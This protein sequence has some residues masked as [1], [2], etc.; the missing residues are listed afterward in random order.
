MKLKAVVL[1]TF[2][3]ELVRALNKIRPIIMEKVIGPILKR[4]NFGSAEFYVQNCD[5][6][7]DETHKPMCE[8]RLTGVSVTEDR[9]IKDYFN[10]RAEIERIYKEVIANN[11]VQGVEVQLMVSAML[12]QPVKGST[13]IEGEVPTIT[14]IGEKK[15]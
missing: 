2:P 7:D 4:P 15:A 8:V 3:K 13:L 9:C 11:L 1:D 10:A 6:V 14:V 5:T 12:D